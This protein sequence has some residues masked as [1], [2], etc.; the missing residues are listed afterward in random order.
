MEYDFDPIGGKNQENGENIEIVYSQGIVVFVK[1]KMIHNR[2]KCL[3]VPTIQMFN[4]F[5]IGFALYCKNKVVKISTI[6]NNILSVQNPI[7][8]IGAVLTFSQT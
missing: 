5:M 6:R 4:Y 2:A 3:L 7:S 8:G 1:G